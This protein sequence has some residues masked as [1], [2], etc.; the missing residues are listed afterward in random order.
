M[1]SDGVSGKESSALRIMFLG[2]LSK[3][4]MVLNILAN[5]PNQSFL[6]RSGISDVS[7]G[8][9]FIDVLL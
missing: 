9:L 3:G 5:P 4:R 1:G 2:V 8:N 7:I 6:I